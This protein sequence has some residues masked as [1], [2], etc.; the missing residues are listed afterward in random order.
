MYFTKSIAY[1]ADLH[2]P[3]PEKGKKFG[4]KLTG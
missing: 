2:N 1:F 4:E 3:K